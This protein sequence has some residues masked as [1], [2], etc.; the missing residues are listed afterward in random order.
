MPAIP[1]LFEH[2]PE[3]LLVPLA[4]PLKALY[5][6]ALVTAY[7]LHQAA[8]QYEV[9]KETLLDRVEELLMA[10]EPSAETSNLAWETDVV[11]TVPGDLTE[12]RLLAWR[13]LRQLERCGWFEYEYR[14]ELGQVARFPDYALN[15]LAVLEATSRGERPRVKGLAYNVKQILTDAEQQQ[16]DPG[17]VLYQARSA[18][19]AFLREL[20]LLRANIGRYVERALH[21]E[22]VRDL[23]A[24]QMNDFWPKVVEPS[25]QQFKTSDNVLRFRMVILD[26]LQE[27]GNDPLFVQ[28]AAA[29]VEIQE[30]LDAEQAKAR[31]HDWL[32]QM[33]VEVRSLD[34]LIEEID[35]RHAHYVGLTLGRIRHRLHR[36]ETTETRL[37]DLIR[38]LQAL[39]PAEEDI[40]DD[41]L[42]AYQLQIVGED[43]LYRQPGESEAHV[44]EPVVTAA[45]SD[46][47]RQAMLLQ[48]QESLANPLTRDHIFADIQQRLVSQGPMDLADLPMENDL[49]FLR[50]IALHSYRNEAAAPYQ[51]QIAEDAPL[52]RSGAYIFRN[53]QLQP[54]G[55]S[56]K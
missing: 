20:K 25:Y 12:H 42:E 31:V 24:L 14:R 21:R 28:E 49:E 32:D 4:S 17:F 53:G 35:A 39:P 1:P 2:I 15:L 46:A 48:A 50:L 23:L 8:D 27:L 3:N 18:M 37:V 47:D 6:E 41:L 45:I 36:N 30:G 34:E 13:L 55:E 7:H 56:S 9:T 16:S 43:S 52:V 5:W 22:Q 19:A 33:A 51:L 11:E 54:R 40:W 44:P 38:N 10:R 26:R 29:R